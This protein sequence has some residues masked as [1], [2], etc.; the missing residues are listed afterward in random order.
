MVHEVEFHALTGIRSRQNHAILSERNALNLHERTLKVIP[1]KR[2]DTLRTTTE[3]STFIDSEFALKLFA[4]QGR[5][6]D[7]VY[8]REPR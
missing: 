5:C 1:S 3:R 4:Y 8:T 7:A 6:T 2:G